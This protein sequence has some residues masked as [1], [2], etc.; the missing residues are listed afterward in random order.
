MG[1]QPH[2]WLVNRI[3]ERAMFPLAHRHL[4]GRLIDIGC[5]NK[6]YDGRFGPQVTEHVGLEHAGNNK[7]FE[8]VDLVGTA[9][10]IPAP[11]ASFDS[12]ICSAVLEHLEEPEAALRECLRVLKPGGSA[13]YTI[14]FIW[15]IHEAPRDFYR[16]T[17][18]GIDHLFRKAGFEKIQVLPLSGYWVTASQMFAYYITRRHAGVLHALGVR[19]VLAFLAQC[20]GLVMHRF[21]KSPAWTWMYIVVARKPG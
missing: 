17:R 1:R 4:K 18:Y 12:A 21:D 16:Y 20:W 11:D 19:F 9:Y 5:G 13:I 10:D 3:G 14:P 7:G 8:H 6:P 2:N 15:H